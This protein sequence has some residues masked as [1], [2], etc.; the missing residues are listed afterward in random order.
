MTEPMNCG[1]PETR[2][3][4][5]SL[6]M[7][8]VHCAVMLVIL[9]PEAHGQRCHPSCVV[10]APCINIPNLQPN[11]ERGFENAQLANKEPSVVRGLAYLISSLQ[12]VSVL[13]ET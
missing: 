4:L 6:K 13:L 9:H 5:R 11:N 1:P 12:T 3:V 2:V 7:C 10:L 8:L